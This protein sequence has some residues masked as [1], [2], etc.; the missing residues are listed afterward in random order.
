MVTVLINNYNYSKYLEDCI[1]SVTN[2]SFSDLQIIVVDDGSTDNSPELIKSIS[3]RDNRIIPILKKNGGQA[4][5]FNA[6]YSQITGEYVFFLDSDDEFQPH[7]IDT[8]VEF[9]L[10]HTNCDFLFCALKHI[11]LR[12]RTSRK[13]PH[14]KHFG[15]TQALACIL[16]TSISSITSV[17]SMKKNVYDMLYPFPFEE[18]WVYRVDECLHLGSSL[19]GATKCYMPDVLVN[20]RV[21][22]ESHHINRLGSMDSTDAINRFVEHYM[23]KFSITEQDLSRLVMEGIP[24]SPSLDRDDVYLYRKAIMNAGI[25]TFSRVMCII[26]LGRRYIETSVLKI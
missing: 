3:A 24:T 25:P 26:M 14:V 18:D 12:S 20:Y 11:G 4:S 9:Y 7:Y 21:H 2:Q 1:A 22:H 17:I 19:A 15:D 13:Y 8:G 10:K 23:N 5:C 6:A 16:P